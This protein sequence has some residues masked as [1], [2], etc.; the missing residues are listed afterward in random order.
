MTAASEG[1][2]A[3][4]LAARE[5][6][7]DIER[8]DLDSVIDLVRTAAPASATLSKPAA[9]LLPPPPL[10]TGAPNDQQKKLLLQ[11]VDQYRED[12]AAE[13][14]TCNELREENERLATDLRSL[15]S[16]LKQERAASNALLAGQAQQ[17]SLAEVSASMPSRDAVDAAG[18]SGLTLASA[19][20]QILLLRREVKFL[21]KQ[22]NSVRVD[23][24]SAT[25]REQMQQLR[26]EAAA[27]KRAAAEY[28][29][30]QGCVVQGAGAK[31]IVLL[32]A[33]RRWGEQANQN[34]IADACWIA[35]V[36]RLQIQKRYADLMEAGE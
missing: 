30:S 18:T 14:H 23:Q 28:L 20:S 11:Q 24:D 3:L 9:V 33:T 8:T 7:I 17:Q 29:R 19:A 6:L 1:H 35:E 4:L 22:W 27:A 13:Q 21:Q 15:A 34:D 10:S 32:A 36:A 31:D 25:A 16:Q 2:R 26:D 5:L 12:L